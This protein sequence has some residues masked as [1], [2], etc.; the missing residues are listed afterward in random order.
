VRA[1]YTAFAGRLLLLRGDLCS[2]DG[3]TWTKGMAKFSM[4]SSWGLQAPPGS[5]FVSAG[6]R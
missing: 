1:V 3:A 2:V 6:M 4:G 5:N